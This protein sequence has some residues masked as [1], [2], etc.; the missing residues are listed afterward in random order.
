MACY[1]ERSM[2]R[3]KSRKQLTGFLSR[4]TFLTRYL[5]EESHV[6][7]LIFGCQDA[8]LPGMRTC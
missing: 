3:F 1:K 5:P 4:S 2:F 6:S 7:S 8:T